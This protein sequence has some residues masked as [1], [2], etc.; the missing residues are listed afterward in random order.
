MISWHSLLKKQKRFSDRPKVFPCR[1]INV[2]TRMA[3]LWER[4]G[5]AKKAIECWQRII[6]AE[7][8]M[9][10]AYQK[11]M[12]LYTKRGMRNAA[13]GIYMKFKKQL[14][15]ELNVEPDEVT[16][17]IYRKIAEDVT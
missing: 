13:M 2:L 1:R 8:F 15:A 17:A 16:T 3:S 10:E 4:Q 14:K 11:M 12:L 9:E 7:P 5:K 6:Q